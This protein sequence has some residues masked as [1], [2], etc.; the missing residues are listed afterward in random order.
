VRSSWLTLFW[1][2]DGEDTAGLL[3]PAAQSCSA[4]WIKRSVSTD[5]P[6]LTAAQARLQARMCRTGSGLLAL[7]L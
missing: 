4:E 3:H 7:L 2:I 1:H 5:A 6:T